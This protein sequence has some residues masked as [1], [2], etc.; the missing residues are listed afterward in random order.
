[1][2]NEKYSQSLSLGHS[3]RFLKGVGPYLEKKLARLG[4]GTIEDLIFFF[5]RTYRDKGEIVPISS[6]KE[7]RQQTIEGKVTGH[8]FLPTRKGRLLQVFLGDG[9]N[10]VVLLCF[11][12][13][14]LI[15]RLPLQTKIRVSGIFKRNRGQWETSRFETEFPSKKPFERYVPVYPLTEGLNHGKLCALIERALEESK[16]QMVDVLPPHVRE[17]HRLWSRYQAV[18]E[19]HKMCV[20]TIDE[21]LERRSKAH[22]TIIFEELF[23]FALALRKQKR[24][25]KQSENSPLRPVSEVVKKFLEALPFALTKAQENAYR[26]VVKDL[27]SGQ[28]MHRLLQGDVGSGK[29]VV[30]LLSALHVIGEGRQAA[31]MVPT[32]ILAEQHYNRWNETFAE[33]NVPVVLVRGGGGVSKRKILVEVSEGKHSFVIGTHALIQEGVKFSDLA[34]AIIDEQHRFGVAQRASL[35]DKGDIPHLLVMTATPIPRTLALTLYGNLDIS[36]INEKPMGVKRVQTLHYS[37]HQRSV[38][39]ETMAHCLRKEQQGYVVCPAIEENDEELATV[40]GIK[41]MIK[42]KWL[43]DFR[44]EAI[45]GRI[46]SRDK[47]LLMQEFASGRIDVLV[48]TSIIEVGIDIPGANVLVIENAERFGLAQLHQLRGRIGRGGR[49]GLCLLLSKSGNPQAV[50]RMEVMTETD[51]GFRIS[52]EDLKL[53]GSG[54][55]FGLRQHGLSEFRLAEPYLDWKIIEKAFEDAE[56]ILDEDPSLQKEHNQGLQKELGFRFSGK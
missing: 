8:R 30:A 34:L 15:R 54:E 33:L 12:R 27:S 55:V 44:V 16:S 40:V 25:R 19:L 35:R 4:I 36:V 46:P 9:K 26:D 43:K 5:P 37:S 42:E 52:E 51:D 31:F 18:A 17:R 29:T 56:S 2:Y 22:Q 7:D 32:E 28:P 39:Y 20:S 14:Y 48:A 6:L 11:N 13:E 41:K 38:V 45:H 53:R 3:I 21:M 49:E 24:T 50:R 47:E 23:L 10:N 1:M